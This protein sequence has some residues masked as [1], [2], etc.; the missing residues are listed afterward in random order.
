MQLPPVDR[1]MN[2]AYSGS[3]QSLAGADNAISTKPAATTVTNAPTEST[4]VTVSG[5]KAASPDK[6]SSSNDQPNKDWTAVKKKAT[7]EEAK[8][9]PPEPISKRLI[10]FLN[11]MW[12]ASGSV[13]ELAAEQASA[14]ANRLE[15]EKQKQGLSTN[16]LVYTDPKVKRS[17]GL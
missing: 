17:G 12:K 3:S 6:P 14:E 8:T 7:T 2:W 11:S 5:Q 13:V 10:D 15:R 16:L 4:I 1:S 9:P